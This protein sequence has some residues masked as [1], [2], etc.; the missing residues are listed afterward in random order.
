[1]TES[2]PFR[3]SSSGEG[4]RTSDPAPT[5]IRAD[6][7]AA[8]DGMSTTSVSGS[9]LR[10]LPLQNSRYRLL[11]EVARG[12]M[13]AVVRVWDEELKRTSAMKIVLGRESESGAASTPLDARLLDR[14]LSEAQITGQLDHPNIVPVHELGVW[15]D[16]RTYFTMR[17]VNGEDLSKI[18]ARVREASDGWTRE[19]ALGVLLKVCEA[20]SYAH[21]KGVVH[22]DLKPSNVMVGKFGEVYVMDWGLARVLGA[23]DQHDLR[24]RPQLPLPTSAVRTRRASERSDNPDS[25]L[26]TMDGDVVGTPSYMAPEQARG[27]LAR[28]GAH[29]DVYSIGAMLYELLAGIAPYTPD[30]GR[31]SAHTIL[32]A[33]LHGPPRSL[34]EMAV[35]APDELVSIVERAMSRDVAQRYSCTVELADDLRAYLEGR[36][37]AAH[38]TGFVT[39]ATKWVRRN[40]TLAASAA[41][42]VVLALAATAFAIQWA[43]ALQAAKS[44]EGA[45]LGSL[46]DEAFDRLLESLASD[47]RHIPVPGRYGFA[48]LGGA[49]SL[50]G[51]VDIRTL[52]AYVGPKPW[53][54]LHHEAVVAGVTTKTPLLRMAFGR[55]SRITL[56]EE[57]VARPAPASDPL[58]EP[59]QALLIK[60][61]RPV[62][63]NTTHRVEACLI[64]PSNRLLPPGSSQSHSTPPTWLAGEFEFVRPTSGHYASGRIYGGRLAAPN[65]Q[66]SNSQRPDDEP[67]TIWEEE[68][69]DADNAS[70]AVSRIVAR[71]VE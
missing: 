42:A 41:V 4:S 26:M 47:S 24:L 17:L 45:A 56:S 25:P 59:L 55:E 36:V 6:R 32:A 38:R 34:G 71:F 31:A 54:E 49:S 65:A 70:I 52:F 64:G 12:G 44:A 3:D 40:R 16:G 2:D 18:Y 10:R 48:E 68:Y 63:G 9:E 53:L 66:L 27:E 62:G 8:A 11:G 67:L 43:I 46:D 5:Q 30:S 29:S 60:V 1:M 50:L 39:R 35:S 23:S 51:R 28:V 7:G 57:R 13:G 15:E 19:R 21:S 14:F 69:F 22:R 58:V 37:V 20:V 33:V 61:E